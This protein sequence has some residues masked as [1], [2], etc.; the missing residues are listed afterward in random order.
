MMN[1][2]DVKQ[3]VYVYLDGEFAR[4]ETR[5]FEAHLVTCAACRGLVDK[6]AHFLRRIR[7]GLPAVKA[8]EQ[9]HERLE[10]ALMGAQAPPTSPLT[11]PS[12]R[13]WLDRLL[14]W[15]WIAVPTMV[16]V[17]L[18]VFVT[19]RRADRGAS[20]A[21]VRAAIA[22]HESRLPVEVKGSESEIRSFLQNNV[23]FAV[24]IPVQNVS[25]VDLVGARLTEIHGDPAIIYTYRM[26]QRR[27]SVVQLATDSSSIHPMPADGVAV[28]EHGDVKVVTYHS[29][30]LTNSLVGELE[31]GALKQVM[32][33]VYR[34]R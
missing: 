14:G 2:D 29:G 6:E 34:G 23:R 15:S 9:L 8:P 24:K 19:S 11:S 33:V 1:C 10:V 26:G 18:V 12:E 22:A 20:E 31:A 25:N 5:D 32:P 4:Q 30:G 13:G 27:F 28:N 16:A 17:A 7:Q 3:G 21:V